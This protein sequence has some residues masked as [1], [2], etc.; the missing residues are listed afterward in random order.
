MFLMLL[1]N[2]NDK[3][4]LKEIFTFILLLTLYTSVGPFTLRR[5]QT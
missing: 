4:I 3:N 2:S 1:N 5:W